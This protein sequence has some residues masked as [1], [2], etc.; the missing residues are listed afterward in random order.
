M[1]LFLC[2]MSR[3]SGAQAFGGSGAHEA[4]EFRGSEV[5]GLRGFRI[6]GAQGFRGS[7]AHEAQEFRGS[8]AQGF[9]AESLQVEGFE[10]YGLC[11]FLFCVS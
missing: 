10:E 7:G 1:R 2:Q 11:S 9:R 8:G 4:Q 5:Q 6:S 3:G